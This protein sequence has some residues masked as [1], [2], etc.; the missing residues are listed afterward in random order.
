MLNRDRQSDGSIFAKAKQAGAVAVT[1]VAFVVIGST[2]MYAQDRSPNEGQKNKADPAESPGVRLRFSVNLPIAG[3]KKR[4][5][6]TSTTNGVR[7]ITVTEGDEQIEMTD[8]NGKKITFKHT[9][10]VKGKPET[11]TVEAADLDELK[12]KSPTLASFYEQYTTVPGAQVLAGTRLQFPLNPGLRRAGQPP[13]PLDDE[14]DRI[15]RS[16]RRIRFEY[17]G[18]KFEITDGIGSSIR[19]RVTKTVEGGQQTD[20]FLA[21]N[22]QQFQDAHPDLY[23]IYEKYTGVEV[24]KPVP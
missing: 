1:F 2:T 5:I 21:E 18:R 19:M 24:D 6:R 4:Q 13:V 12:A 23:R 11:S 17:Q 16:P 9:R 14:I 10:P 15:E 3:P 20:E 22:R 8:T 7:T